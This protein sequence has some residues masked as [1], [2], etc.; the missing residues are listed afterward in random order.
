MYF[1]GNNFFP[2]F[3]AAAAAIVPTH[4]NCWKTTTKESRYAHHYITIEIF[5]TLS[6]GI[7]TTKA[8]YAHHYITIEKM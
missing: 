3:L 2:Q 1:V 6:T 7:T 8:D 5:Y 4:N